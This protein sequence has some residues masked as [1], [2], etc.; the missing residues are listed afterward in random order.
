MKSVI[1]R[2]WPLFSWTFSERERRRFAIVIVSTFKILPLG[3]ALIEDECG[4]D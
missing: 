2:D 1:R 3:K 4:D